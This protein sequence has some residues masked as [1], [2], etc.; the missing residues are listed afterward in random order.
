MIQIYTG[1][2][3]GKTTAALGLALRALGHN[4]KVFLIQFLKKGACSGELKAAKRFKGFKVWQ[5]GPGVRVSAS[6]P[7]LK[8]KLLVQKGLKLA[9]KVLAGKEYDLVIL[10]EL[11]VALKCGLL[12]LSHVKELLQAAEKDVE[13]VLTGRGAHPQI[14][15]AADLVS[16]IKEIRHYYKKGLGPRAGIEY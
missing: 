3:K 13:L 11:N 5:T 16:E 15:K 10:D 9:R 1:N 4:K 2:G 6:R 7:T 8:N 12:R 14:I